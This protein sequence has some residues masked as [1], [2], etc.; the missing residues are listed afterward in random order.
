MRVVESAYT[1]QQFENWRLIINGE[2]KAGGLVL[3]TI[4][5]TFKIMCGTNTVEGT[6]LLTPGKML[7]TKPATI[8]VD[9]GA[10]T[11]VTFDGLELQDGAVPANRKFVS[12][13][14]NGTLVFAIKAVPPVTVGNI[15]TYVPDDEVDAITAFLKLRNNGSISRYRITLMSTKV[16]TWYD[17][18]KTLYPVFID[19]TIEA[20]RSTYEFSLIFNNE[21]S[22]RKYRYLNAGSTATANSGLIPMTGSGRNPLYD[23][24]LNATGTSTTSGWTCPYNSNANY[25]AFRNFICLSTG[26]TILKDGNNFWFRSIADPADWFKCEPY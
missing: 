25:T 13:D 23:A 26:F 20:P 7:F 22:G 1:L 17:N 12:T 10:G 11:A 9:E 2:K 4:K 19:W 21:D 15:E 5:R 14:P 16:Q 3:D 24:T 6:Y 8:V 18:L